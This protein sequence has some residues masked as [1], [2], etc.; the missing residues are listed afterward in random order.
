VE[1]YKFKMAALALAGLIAAAPLAADEA[2]PAGDTQDSIE[3]LRASIGTLTNQI[4]SIQSSAKSMI[5]VHGFAETDVFNDNT[6]SFTEVVGNGAVKLEGLK[7]SSAG[8]NGQTQ[9]SVRNSRIDFLAQADVNGWKG[10]GYVEFDL[11]GYDPSPAWGAASAVNSAG[12]TATNAAAAPSEG[13]FYTNATLRVRHAYLDAQKDGWDIMAGQ[14]WT[15]LGWNMDYTLATVS[16]APVMGVLYQRDPQV[17]LGYTLFGNGPVKIQM[18][19]DAE[20]P[21]ERES[22]QPNYD[23]GVR[24]I[25]PG[26]QGRFATATGDAKAVPMSVGISGDEREFAWQG[27]LSNTALSTDTWGKALAIDALVPIIP[28]DG[29][30]S[31]SMV[32]TGEWSVGSGDGDA[33][34]SW[35][36]GASALS[37]TTGAADVDSGLAYLLGNYKNFTLVQT[38]SWNAQLQFHLMPSIGT[39]MTVGYGQLKSPNLSNLVGAING[40]TGKAVTYGTV[41]DL[42]SAEF[43]NVMQDFGPNIRAALEFA[44]FYTHYAGNAGNPDGQGAMDNR[45][46]LS[47]WYRF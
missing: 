43:V 13:A 17:R 23:Q 6:Q 1:H 33:F 4:N 37:T 9:M 31:M 30:D 45:I 42:D 12:S 21:V 29:K 16:V 3:D 2:A 40:A 46:Q 24:F 35:S 7:A 14:D 19:A 28:F 38:T 11:L 44:R 39:F 36:G 5:Q 8:A 32:A 20:R 47:T 10:K 34:P 26:W 27:T 25:I 18:A 15:L 41:Y 22:S